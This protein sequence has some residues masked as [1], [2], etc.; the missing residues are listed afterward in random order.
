[1]PATPVV[2]TLPPK[3]PV[4]VI[5]AEPPTAR[6]AASKSESKVTFAATGIATAP[7]VLPPPPTALENVTLPASRGVELE[8]VCSVKVFAV[9]DWT[10]PPKLISPT[11]V[12]IARFA[13][14]C[15]AADPVTAKEPTPVRVTVAPSKIKVVPVKLTPDAPLVA[16]VLSK[17]VVPV[18]ASCTNES[19]VNAAPTVTLSA[20]TTVTLPR[21]V[22]PPTMPGRLI[23]LPLPGLSVKFCA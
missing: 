17:V 5:G 16:T 13:P 22:D 20:V 21:G 11:L 3:V 14:I 2:S 7:R 9:V 15:V 4:P 18:P 6:D 8:P 23:E 12:V 19:A 1:M 10:V